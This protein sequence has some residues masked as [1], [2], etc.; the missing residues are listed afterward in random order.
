MQGT[1][2]NISEFMYKLGIFT[3]R[4]VPLWFERIKKLELSSMKKNTV[5]RGKD[6]GNSIR[7]RL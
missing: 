1:V 4:W 5:A 6:M 2:L 3:T 7:E